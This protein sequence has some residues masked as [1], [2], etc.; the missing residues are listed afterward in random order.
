MIALTLIGIS[1]VPLMK[2]PLSLFRS[3]IK[4]L[5]I[6]EKERVADISLQEVIEQITQKKLLLPEIQKNKVNATKVNLSN[7]PVKMDHSHIIIER[8]C[9]L[10]EIGE[11]K[12]KDQHTY[13]MIALEVILKTPNTKPTH[14]KKKILFKCIKT[15][16]N[17]LNQKI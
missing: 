16:S 5:Q 12:A 1:S 8:S 4:N 2:I 11:K 15:K 6:I 14:Y 9:L 13:K 17:N 10:W 3:Q 7:Y